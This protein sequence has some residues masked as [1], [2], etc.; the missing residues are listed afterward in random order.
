MA[1]ITTWLYLDRN[2]NIKTL[3][4]HDDTVGNHV[5]YLPEDA[6]LLN[7]Y[8][9]DIVTKEIFETG[10]DYVLPTVLE[11]CNKQSNFALNNQIP[12]NAFRRK[13]DIIKFPVD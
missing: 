9:R 10:F 5:A 6:F 11:L 3:D 4:M 7:S 8:A 13:G 2:R 12:E 1:T